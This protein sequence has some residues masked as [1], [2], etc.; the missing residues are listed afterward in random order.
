MIDYLNIE[1]DKDEFNEEIHNELRHHKTYCERLECD[2][3]LILERIMSRMLKKN[4]TLS[5]E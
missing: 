2:V 1:I 5:K 4:L 3:Y